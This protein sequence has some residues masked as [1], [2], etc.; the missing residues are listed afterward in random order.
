MYV[1]ESFVPKQF[2]TLGYYRVWASLRIDIAQTKRELEVEFTLGYGQS[3]GVV[4]A[5]IHKFTLITVVVVLEIVVSA[6]CIKTEC[7]TLQ[8][9]GY[10]A[11]VTKPIAT[12][13]VAG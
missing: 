2:A 9:L 13:N 5:D 7:V 11:L 10:G 1:L 8:T 4:D 12:L 6:T 3:V